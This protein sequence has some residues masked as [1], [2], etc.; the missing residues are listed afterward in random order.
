MQLLFILFGYFFSF[1]GNTIGDDGAQEFAILLKD[2]ETLTYLGYSGFLS[3]SFYLRISRPI[4]VI[5]ALLLHKL[6]SVPSLVN[7]SNSGLTWIVVSPFI[8]F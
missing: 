2:N 5:L 1:H 3:V 4:S 6:P 7:L 8:R